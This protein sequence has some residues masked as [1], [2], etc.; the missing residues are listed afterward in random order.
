MLMSSSHGFIARRGVGE[1]LRGITRRAQGTHRS[2]TQHPEPPLNAGLS[3]RPIQWRKK[4]NEAQ[5]SGPQAL[6][7]E[8]PCPEEEGVRLS[9]V[10][11]HGNHGDTGG[12]APHR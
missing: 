12:P 2:Q 5:D 11:H 1:A 8:D 9:S 7:G 4:S 3:L 10:H 6:R